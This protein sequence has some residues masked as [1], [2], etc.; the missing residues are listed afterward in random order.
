MLSRTL[1]GTPQWEDNMITTKT[2]KHELKISEPS[3]VLKLVS[4]ALLNPNLDHVF[5]FRYRHNP[6]FE[7]EIKSETRKMDEA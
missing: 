2:E 6:H 4:E 1:R 5:V 7:V 3:E